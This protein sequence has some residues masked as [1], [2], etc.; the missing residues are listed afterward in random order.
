MLETARE[1]THTELRG[2]SR[3]ARH[4]A[5][6]SLGRALDGWRARIDGVLVQLDLA[7]LEL[8]DELHADIDAAEHAYLTARLRVSEAREDADTN[9]ANLRKGVERLLEDVRSAVESAERAVR[10]RVVR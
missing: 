6:E 5:V 4:D 10:E 7:S 3:D 9:V 1:G 8:R 2:Q